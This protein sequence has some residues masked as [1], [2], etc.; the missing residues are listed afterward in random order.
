MVNLPHL[1]TAM[2]NVTW[3]ILLRNTEAAIGGVLYEELFL[4][5][6]KIHRKT[7]VA[8]NFA[9]FL[10]TAFLQNTSGQVLLEEK[11]NR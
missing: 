5:I 4:E 7:N 10:R 11:R 9:K 2:R 1:T 6:H 3:T 8:M